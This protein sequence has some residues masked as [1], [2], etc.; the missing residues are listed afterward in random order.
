M[1][2]EK[3]ER[4]CTGLGMNREDRNGLADRQDFKGVCKH[5]LESNYR[6]ILVDS[7]EGPKLVY[8]TDNGTDVDSTENLNVELDTDMNRKAVCKFPGFRTMGTMQCNAI[9]LSW[10]TNVLDKELQNGAA[11]AKTA[12]EV[13]ADLQEW[14]TRG[15][16]PR[17]YKLKR[18]I[19][20]LQQEK[21]LISTYYGR[22]KAV[23][24]EL[25]A[26]N[27]VPTCDCGC[28]YGAA[29]K[30]QSMREE[31]KVFDFLMG[32]DESFDTIRS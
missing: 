19:E 3:A 18:A 14:F 20:L 27:H 15:L 8:G 26:L 28:T 17:V 21:A 29:K 4:D 16:A 23:W 6:I 30:M 12:N 32:L 31:E 2:W 25:Q 7:D 1:K 10:I 11:Y 9:V 13:W 5:K 24:N 22:L